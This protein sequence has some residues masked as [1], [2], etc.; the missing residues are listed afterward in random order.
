MIGNKF[1]KCLS[2]L[3]LLLSFSSVLFAT[4]IST[5]V[6]GLCSQAKGLLAIGIMLLIILAALVYSIGQILGAETRARAS[7][8]ATAMMTGA[9]IGVI[10]Y[11]IVPYVIGLINST[12]T[13]TC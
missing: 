9:I 1:G 5:A 8:W 4:N 10:I 12:L 13:T 6:S 2:I 7:V 11:I 3:V